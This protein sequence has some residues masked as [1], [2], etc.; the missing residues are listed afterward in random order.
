PHLPGAVLILL[1]I[2][3]AVRYVE[4][5]SRKDALLAG[6]LCGATFGMVL[7]GALAFILL[8]AMVWMSWRTRGDLKRCFLDLTF[9]ILVGVGVYCVT[10][11]FVLIHLLGD[12]TIL[13]SNLGNTQ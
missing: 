7:T 4:S 5:G 9:A 13:E 6:L 12:R 11:P 2:I 3:A 10:N 8:P 1:G